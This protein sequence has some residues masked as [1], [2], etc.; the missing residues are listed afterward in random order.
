MNTYLSN[1]SSVLSGPF[2]KASSPASWFRRKIGVGEN[3]WFSSSSSSSVLNKEGE[4]C[5]ALIAGALTFLFSSVFAVAFLASTLLAL[6][7]LD[8]FFLLTTKSSRE[9]SVVVLT[10]LGNTGADLNVPSERQK[11][12]DQG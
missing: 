12:Q 1:L 10:W 4:W 3:E 9:S 2:P 7:A 11:D 6:M 5:F 8:D